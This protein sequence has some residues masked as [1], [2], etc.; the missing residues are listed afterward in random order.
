MKRFLALLSIFVMLISGIAVFNACGYDGIDDG[1][2]LDTGSASIGGVA[3]DTQG[4]TEND[5][6]TQSESVIDEEKMEIDSDRETGFGEIYPL[7]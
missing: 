5:K 1:I 2:V 4:D 7:G 6:E 3:F